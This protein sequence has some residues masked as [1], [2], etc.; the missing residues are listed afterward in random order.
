MPH[1]FK[2]FIDLYNCIPEGNVCIV[3]IVYDIQTVSFSCFPVCSIYVDWGVNV[4]VLCIISVSTELVDMFINGAED[5]M[6][7]CA[8]VLKLFMDVMVVVC[9]TGDSPC[10][11]DKPFPYFASHYV[12]LFMSGCFNNTSL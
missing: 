1:Y 4:V 9:L 10:L 7:A 12:F 11:E 2:A 6:Y 3:W 8:S 5:H